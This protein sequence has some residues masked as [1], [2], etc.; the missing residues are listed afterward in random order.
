MSTSNKTTGKSEPVKKTAYQQITDALIKADAREW[1]S[2]D[3][4]SSPV[5]K[6]LDLWVLRGGYSVWL[7]VHHNG[8]YNMFSQCTNTIDI[9]SDIDFITQNSVL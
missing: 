1:A 7:H 9:Q 5:I 8:S 2:F 4:K 6:R 3:V